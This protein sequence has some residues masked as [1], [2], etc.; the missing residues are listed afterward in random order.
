MRHDKHLPKIQKA[1]LRTFNKLKYAL[2]HLN[3]VRYLIHF[4][5]NISSDYPLPPTST[6]HTTHPHQEKAIRVKSD[7]LL[8]C[9]FV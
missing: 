8:L 7:L 4:G 5:D 1:M 6:G 2:S 9:I 3:T